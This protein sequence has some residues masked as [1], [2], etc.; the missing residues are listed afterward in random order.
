MHPRP[1]APHRVRG[2]WLRLLAIVAALAAAGCGAGKITQTSEQVSAVN[3]SSLEIGHIQ[4]HNIYLDH[5]P[6]D[7]AERARLAFTVVNTSGSVTDRLV[8]IE[9]PAAAVNILAPPGALTLAPGTVLAAGQPIEQLIEPAAPY[10]PITVALSVSGGL[11]PGLTTPFTFVF[12]VAGTG[13]VAVPVDV[14]APGEDV[15]PTREDFTAA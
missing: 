8:S 14:W 13:T 11:R 10:E 9:S 3:G 2:R 7:P 4:V 15:P 6:G 1:R 12:E 5:D